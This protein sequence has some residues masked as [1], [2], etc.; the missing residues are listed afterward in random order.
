MTA[1]ITVI[2]RAGK[3]A[4]LRFTPAG[5]AVTSISLAHTERVKDGDQWKDGETVWFEISVWGYQAEAAAAILK[6][7]QVVV[8]GRFGVS[9][10]TTK[11]G[12]T[13]T[14]FAITADGFGVTPAVNSPAPAAVSAP[15]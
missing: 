10:Y 13:R 7:N 6:G 12:E 15:F 11:D 8:T 9:E 14:K 4:E 1:T 3:D 5:K 2:G